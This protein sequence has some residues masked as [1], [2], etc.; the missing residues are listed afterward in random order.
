[1][2]RILAILLAVLLTAL[3]P[4][5]ITGC[6]STSTDTAQSTSQTDTDNSAV[7]SA[8]NADTTESSDSYTGKTL[9]I[10]LD[11]EPESLLVQAASP[12][13]GANH[14]DRCLYN[15]LYE[16]DEDGNYVPALA[17]GYEWIDE[18]HLRV[19]LR[20]GVAFYDG[21]ELTA[22]DVIYSW[23]LGLEG[24][25]NSSYETP[26]LPNEFYAEDDYTVV[27]V[28][29]S[30][31]P[32]FSDSFFDTAYAII[33]KSSVES[34]G[35]MTD[36]S[37]NPLCNSG[38][39]NFVEW[40]AGQYV[41][42]E[43]NE[44]YWDTSYV[45]EY[46]YIKFTFIPD[47]ASRCLAVKSG[48]AD[49]AVCI[50]LSDTLAYTEDTDVTIE[51]LASASTGGTVLWYRC[52]TG[53]FSDENVRFALNYLIDW[54][55]CAKV[56]TGSEDT[57]MQGWFNNGSPYYAGEDTRTY[58]PQKGIELLEASGYADGFSFNLKIEPTDGYQTVAELIQA[59][60]LEANIQADL[61]NVDYANWF[62]MFADAD[63]ECYIGGAASTPLI[64][65]LGY[66]DAR[67]GAMSLG[68]PQIVTDEL[69]AYLDI[70]TTTFDDDERYTAIMGMQEYAI[71]HA[72]C[73]GVTSLV[74][75][76]LRNNSICNE[77][78]DAAGY[79]LPYFINPVS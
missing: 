35:G 70:A 5:S 64:Y 75:Y 58:D 32:Y 55:A 74:H 79:V 28:F 48:E 54:K 51:T 16:Y 30:A 71:E 2:K 76:T 4:L 47:S 9:T 7:E 23:Q 31:Y 37:L 25:A 22:E 57:V 20:E 50:T 36:I 66:M 59:Y 44:N 1:M 12:N 8:G 29:D 18:T 52:D 69:A 53:P 13:A 46:Q 14:I 72:L 40:V 15:W 24:T 77:V 60:L 49:M 34:I 41:L 61:I 27:F 65:A 62:T 43:Y 26:F 42:V 67:D 56:L 3:L 10:A 17:T 68:G 73:Q 39:Y 19:T 11:A 45:P 33:S 38:R 21:S 63:Y 6:G 78:P